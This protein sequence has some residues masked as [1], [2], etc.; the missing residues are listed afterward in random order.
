MKKIINFFAKTFA[1]KRYCPKDNTKM[2]VTGVEHDPF[3]D[4]DCVSYVCPTCNS[5]LHSPIGKYKGEIL[6]GKNR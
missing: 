6:T 5:V 2:K 3:N 4:M 1:H